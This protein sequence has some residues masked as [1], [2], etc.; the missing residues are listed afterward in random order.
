MKK[1]KRAEVSYAVVFTPAE[2]GGYTATV[3]SLPGC[4]SEGDSF[5]EAKENIAEAIK[6]YTEVIAFSRSA[7]SG[8]FVIAP[9]TV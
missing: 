3:P 2:E 5:E 9:V 4:I 6:L 8:D 7:V 1:R